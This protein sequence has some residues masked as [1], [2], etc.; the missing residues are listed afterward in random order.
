M[1]MKKFE[2]LATLRVY[3][4]QPRHMPQADPSLYWMHDFVLALSSSS[5]FLHRM[6]KIPQQLL[7]AH[8]TETVQNLI[9]LVKYGQFNLGL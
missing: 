4:D 1:F 8:S 2:S 6:S 7:I 9:R 5:T 3:R